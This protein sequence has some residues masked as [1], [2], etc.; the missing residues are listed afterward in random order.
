MPG[1]AR[2]LRSRELWLGL[3]LQ[4]HDFSEVD[5]IGLRIDTIKYADFGEKLF[6]SFAEQGL[7]SF[8]NIMLSS[9][10]VSG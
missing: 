9:I 6:S 2:L 1:R 7:L 4:M 5:F 3:V 8:Q 10:V